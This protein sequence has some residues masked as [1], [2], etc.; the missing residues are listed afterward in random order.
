MDFSLITDEP[1]NYCVYAHVNKTNGKMY[2]GITCRLEHR[3]S[4]NGYYYQP[5]TKFYRAIQK[6]GW[7]NF[8]HIVLIDGISESMAYIYEEQLIV[9][10]DTQNNG[11]NILPGGQCGGKIGKKV[12]Q[13]DLSGNFIR[14]WE[15]ALVASIETGANHQSLC[16]CARNDRSQ[17]S[18]GGY[19]WRYYKKD[20]I[21]PYNHEDN[22]IKKGVVLQFSLDGKLI[23]RYTDIYYSD[24]FTIS[25]I[26]R[27]YD[28]CNK[29]HYAYESFWFWENEYTEDI[30]EKV[31]RNRSPQSH[32][33]EKGVITKKVYKYSLNGELLDTY[34]SVVEASIKTN[35][36]Y[37]NINGAC[38][39]NQK[40]HYCNGYLWY[41]YADCKGLKNVQPFKGV[42]NKVKL[43]QYSLD[44]KFIKEY[45]SI[46][47]ANL[48]FKGLKDT[49]KKGKSIHNN[50][51]WFREFKG[52]YIEM[53][54]EYVK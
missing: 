17:Q 3:W 11:Y 32:F 54:V 44:G 10:Y 35:I 1:L 13:Y 5:S 24:S 19:Q 21:S 8:D 20:K 34:E 40:N 6:Y 42:R 26:H 31:I 36:S 7:D 39:R 30:L 33:H 43:Y 4:A 25:Q 46:A 49:L 2:I 52:N 51:L 14:E 50:F 27:I 41:Y 22:H 12:Y 47:Q 28:V 38:N 53:E 45:E 15:N 37:G 23:K 9:K 18:S 48:E 29:N 16:K